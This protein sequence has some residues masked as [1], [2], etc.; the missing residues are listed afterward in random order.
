MEFYVDDAIF[1][2]FPGI[3]FV[4]VVAEGINP[5]KINMEAIEHM[6]REGWKVAG[7]AASMYG[8]PQSHPNIKPWVSR[9]KAI[10]VSRKNFLIPLNLWCAEQE[11]GRTFSYYSSGRFL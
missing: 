10:G 4:C 1:K 6:L 5:E 3:R 9:L 7:H 11:R 8:N 2:L